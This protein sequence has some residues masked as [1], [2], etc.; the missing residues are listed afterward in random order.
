MVTAEG[1]TCWDILTEIQAEPMLGKVVKFK[2]MISKN[3]LKGAVLSTII[4]VLIMAPFSPIV[5]HSNLYKTELPIS[6]YSILYE[7]FSA[8]VKKDRKFIFF[9]DK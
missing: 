7:E 6:K 4:I 2:N 1:C 5:N 9:P 8:E 3:I